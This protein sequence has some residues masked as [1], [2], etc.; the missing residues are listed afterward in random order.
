[1]LAIA[2]GIILA[3]L[4]LLVLRFIYE[5]I[6]VP[7]PV[8]QKVAEKIQSDKEIIIEEGRQK[9]IEWEKTHPLSKHF[10]K[11]DKNKYLAKHRNR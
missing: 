1:M 3:V 4:G 7:V 9:H 5:V 8:S 2:G 6:F 10:Y 11:Y